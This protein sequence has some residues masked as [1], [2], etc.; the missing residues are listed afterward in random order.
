MGT[1]NIDLK[2]AIVKGPGTQKKLALILPEHESVVSDVVRGRRKLTPEKAARW[3][4]VLK[5]DPEIIREVTID[6]AL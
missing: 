1:I 5:C 6:R 3:L 4:D 2:V